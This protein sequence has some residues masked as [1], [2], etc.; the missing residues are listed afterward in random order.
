MQRTRF[1]FD[2]I[3]GPVP[4]RLPAKQESPPDPA[5]ADQACEVPAVAIPAISRHKA[6]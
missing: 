2:V 3:A 1:D 4:P 6:S 5:T